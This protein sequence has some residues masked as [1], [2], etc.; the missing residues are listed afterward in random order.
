MTD[1]KSLAKAAVN[2]PGGRSALRHLLQGERPY[3]VLKIAL[4]VV[5]AAIVIALLV[6]LAGQR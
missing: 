2:P 5:A 6:W 4:V 1:T 3:S